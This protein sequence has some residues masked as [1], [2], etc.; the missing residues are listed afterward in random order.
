[1]IQRQEFHDRGCVASLIQVIEQVPARAAVRRGSCIQQSSAGLL[2]LWSAL[3]WER[4]YLIQTLERMGIDLWALTCDVDD[5]LRQSGKKAADPSREA[6]REDLD[7]VLLNW[8]ERAAMQAKALGYGYVG[9]EHLVLAMLASADS[10]LAPIFDRRGLTYDALK[11]AISDG[12]DGSRAS[13]VIV[14][15]EGEASP[16]ATEGRSWIADVDRPAVGVPRRFGVFLMMLMVT[17]YAVL[18]SFLRWL[19]APELIFAMVALFF[20]GIGIGQACLFGGRYPRAASIWVGSI[21]GPL[22][23]SGYVLWRSYSSSGFFLSLL[24]SLGAFLFLIPVGAACG[25][26]IGTVTAGGFWLV[27]LYE[28]RHPPAGAPPGE[29]HAEC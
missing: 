14:L 8:I 13:Q 26:L 19:R 18:F 27:D 10:E 20:T 3:R 6:N 1:V 11:Q 24:L 7:S 21:L 4:T 16:A 25:Y 28:K 5:S 15:D 22:E 17:Q 2:I 12:L 9:T 23:V 29:G